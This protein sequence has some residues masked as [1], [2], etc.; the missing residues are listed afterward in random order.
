MLQWYP[1]EEDSSYPDQP[2]DVGLRNKII[3][4]QSDGFSEKQRINRD[5]EDL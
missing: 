2:F 5:N 4:M 3:N 1:I